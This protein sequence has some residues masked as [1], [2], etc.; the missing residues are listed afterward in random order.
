MT[1]GT[2][3]E[4]VRKKVL[5]FL[6][7]AAI[8]FVSDR[9]GNWMANPHTHISPV[10]PA[11]GACIAALYILGIHLWP[12]V[13]GS[14]LVASG[15]TPGMGWEI[16][17]F[18]ACNCLE[19]VVGAVVLR[20]ALEKMPG[21][22]A[23]RQ[24]VAIVATALVGPG[25]DAVCGAATLKFLLGQTQREFC[26]NLL[27]WWAGDAIGVIAVLPAVLAIY[28]RCQGKDCN[29][30]A[31]LVW[32][33][34]LVLFAVVAVGSTVFW[35]SWGSATLFLLF[36]TLL[37]AAILMDSMGANGAALLLVAIGA[38]ATSFSHGPFSNGSLDQNLL[39]LDFFA[40]SVPLAAL[41]LSVLGEEGSLL[42]PGVVLLAGWALS[43]W[44]FASLT[45]ERQAFDDLQFKRLEMNSEKDIQE[46]MASYTGGLMGSM[47]F[48]IGTP[49]DNL[50][51]WKT[52]IDSQ[53]LL[54]GQHG[55]TGI[56]VVQVVQ[57]SELADFERQARQSFGPDFHV[58]T[59]KDGSQSPKLPFHYIIVGTEPAEGNE[60][61]MGIDLT[62]EQNRLDAALE[63]AATG[64]PAITRPFIM[65]SGKE[66]V[67]VFSVFVPIYRP[68]APVQT[69]SQ[70][71]Q[72]IAGFVYAPIRVETPFSD[73]LDRS[74]HQLDIA[75]FEGASLSPANLIFSSAAKPNPHFVATTRIRLGGRLLTLGW[76]RGSHFT[77]QRNT[78]AIWASACSAILTLLLACLV[79]S[80]QSVG[81]RANRI[82]AERTAALAASRDQLAAALCAADA[83]NEAKS[84]F[85]AVMSHEI[86][87]PMNGILGMNGLLGQTKLTAEQIE[88][89]QAIQLSGEALLTLINDILDFSKIES[90]ELSLE[91]H[92]LSLRQC[93]SDSVT[94]FSP[95]ASEKNLDLTYSCDQ[96]IPEFVLGDVGR[97]RQILLNLIGNAVKF[98]QA[99]SVKVRL[100]CLEKTATDCMISISVED[101]GIGIPD[102]A[103]S[104]LFERFSKGDA[105]TTRRF[106]GAGLGLA[107]SR[108]LV[109]MM[110]GKFSFESKVDIGSTFAF[111]LR[112]QLSESAQAELAPRSR[113][114]Q[115]R[116][117]V[118]DDA[119]AAATEVIH[120]LQRVG[121]RHQLAR[122][123]EEAVRSLNEARLSADRYA[124]AMVPDTMP[125][126]LLAL[127][128]AIQ[129]E[130][131]VQK[132]AL[133]VIESEPQKAREPEINQSQF[134]D[135]IEA[136]LDGAK[137]FA[138]LARAVN[139]QPSAPIAAPKPVISTS[140][141]S[142][143]LIVEDNLINQ[144]VLR[145][146]M[147]RLGY[148]ADLAGNGVEALQKWSEGNYL[149]I[150][151][152]CQMPEMDGFEATR[153]IRLREGPTKHTPI[154]AVTAN[155]M[156]GD[157]EKCLASGMDAFV[158]KP[159]KT[160][161]LTK[162][163]QEVLSA[164]VQ[165]PGILA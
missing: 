19:A 51:Q 149:F 8:Y 109:E 32:R 113:L 17:P 106:G 103:Q 135:V 110:G 82:A 132:T 144:K 11:S 66:A 155:A 75:V 134:S 57:D 99:G 139:P 112:M 133:I 31:G 87:T 119:T 126:T 61:A 146:L 102:E 33:T 101:T 70:R 39:Q 160:E 115:T 35:S 65:R 42:W 44:L 127:S 5:R 12:A 137:V 22:R 100:D 34:P 94:L 40:V 120:H 27:S 76:N 121:V 128:R 111:N 15:W 56:G 49:K 117:L 63:A 18:S 153:E 138:A 85:L 59:L 64:D 6:L 129:S 48:L 125:Q 163:I 68:G 45:Q 43:G 77:S 130:P 37:L 28:Q 80:L 156:L 50:A 71:R 4:T 30:K 52:W 1:D 150:L 136:P 79:T 148:A 84:E 145:R 24:A 123:Q 20:Y 81:A 67:R 122:T 23:I 131:G 7:V 124:V 55:V 73:V 97:L 118:V 89:V 159:V 162:A 108:N 58:K 25:I 74:G 142:P 9:A 14:A 158:P 98:T 36:P 2:A 95:R 78:A 154:I 114:G 3:T 10:W 152:D 143:I 62:T 164:L 116:V 93:V 157:R 53:R 83:A 46:R 105:T 47:R 72:A 140:G 26:T 92:P 107:I 147:E 151:M 90:R 88:Y 96:Q 104:R 86:R 38:I 69:A 141:D 54:D 165:N 16:V 161:V 21:K 13:L 41:L 91:S 60:W 29:A